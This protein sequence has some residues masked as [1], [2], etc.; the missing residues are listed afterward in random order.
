MMR[1]RLLHTWDETRNATR[2]HRHLD[3]RRLRHRCGRTRAGRLG[4]APDL[5]R[6]AGAGRGAQAHHGAGRP[7]TPGGA[8]RGLARPRGRPRG[9]A[10]LAAA[11]G[12]RGDDRPG[13]G[14][15]AHAHRRNGYARRA[16]RHG[17][18]APGRRGAAGGHVRHDRE[19][20]FAPAGDDVPLGRR[21]GSPHQL[22]LRP[23]GRGRGGGETARSS[24]AAS[25]FRCARTTWALSAPSPS[26]GAGPTRCRRTASSGRSRSSRG[27]ARPRSA[28]RRSSASHASSPTWTG[29]RRCTTAATSTRRWPARPPGR[30]ATSAASRSSSSTSTTSRR[31]TTG[32]ATWAA[33]PCWPPLRSGCSRPCGGG[34]RLPGRRRRV[35]RHPPGSRRP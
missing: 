35:R 25:P 27:R 21:P 12:D 24:A 33:T 10:A 15:R 16:C 9:D 32:S 14:A 3:R 19:G 2:R 17:G 11:G 22:P 30:S 26:S 8:R 5:C 29:S 13:L 28:T 18:G 34:P 23:R 31:R 20:G 4:R 1:P 6:A 7:R